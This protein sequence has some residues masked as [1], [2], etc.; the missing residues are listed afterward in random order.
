[1]RVK[2]PASSTS[3]HFNNT[4]STSRWKWYEPKFSVKIEN[5]K[6]KK[7][8]YMKSHHRHWQTEMLVDCKD[9]CVQ[10]ACSFAQQLFIYSAW[11]FASLETVNAY[12][13]WLLKHRFLQKENTTKKNGNIELEAFSSVNIALCHEFEWMHEWSASCSSLTCFCPVSD[14]NAERLRHP[15]KKNHLRAPDSCENCQ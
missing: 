13:M 7:Q 11:T 6:R 10:H 1:M 3:L 8:M 2:S 5:R 15:R 14:S 12:K 4:L 9:L